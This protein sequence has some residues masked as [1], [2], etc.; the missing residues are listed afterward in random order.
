MAPRILAPP[1]RVIP[2]A[3]AVRI[4]AP[5]AIPVKPAPPKVLIKKAPPAPRD[6]LMSDILRSL[7]IMD[8]YPALIPNENAQKVFGAVERILSHKIARTI[9]QL[10]ENCDLTGRSYGVL[11]DLYLVTSYLYYVKDASTLGDGVYD[12]ICLH[13]TANYADAVSAADRPE[14]IWVNKECK[15]GFWIKKEAYPRRVIAI[16]EQIL[17]TNRSKRLKKRI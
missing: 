13:L 15:S 11:T 14:L 10:N 17:A 6:P 9:E 1:T 12:Q 2:V 4:I 5:P 7:A 8:K 16:A 3:P